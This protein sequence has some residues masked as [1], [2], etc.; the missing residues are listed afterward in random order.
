[1][2]SENKYIWSQTLYDASALEWIIIYKFLSFVCTSLKFYTACW[3]NRFCS[4]VEHANISW[5][6]VS[7]INMRTITIAHSWARYHSKMKSSI[8]IIFIAGIFLKFSDSKL[9]NFEQCVPKV[10]PVDLTKEKGQWYQVLRSKTYDAGK[11]YFWDIIVSGAQVSINQTAR[12]MD[13]PTTQTFNL[14][15]I[16]N[17]GT[18]QTTYQSEFDSFWCLWMS[19]KK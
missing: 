9:S 4:F 13:T 12:Y 2:W 11:C 14:N 7:T 19:H 15:M 3:P 6:K 17:N 10:T 18:Y 1:M 16:K 8:L 5:W